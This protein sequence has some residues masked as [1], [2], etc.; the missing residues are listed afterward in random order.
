MH[1]FSLT[2]FLVTAF[3]R[4]IRITITPPSLD[5]SGPVC[6]LKKAG[7]EGEV[8]IEVTDAITFSSTSYIHSNSS[9]NIA[10]SFSLE[11]LKKRKR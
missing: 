9:F 3:P 4:Y 10:A 11:R 8:I 6:R 5:P 7:I 2:P 1:K